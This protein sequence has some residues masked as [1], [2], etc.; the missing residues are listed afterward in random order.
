MMFMAGFLVDPL[1]ALGGPAATCAGPPER[2]V[3]AQCAMGEFQFT[4]ERLRLPEAAS[5]QGLRGRF[6]TTLPLSRSCSV[7]RRSLKGCIRKPSNAL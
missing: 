5:C 7:W 1:D 3:A 6:N 2:A 4:R